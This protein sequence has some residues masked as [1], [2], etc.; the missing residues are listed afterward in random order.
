[1][2]R[3]FGSPASAL[4]AQART[5]TLADCR[6]L[7]YE[8]CLVATGARALVPP[9]PGLAD[10]P[11]MFTFRDQHDG[12]RLT[13]ALGWARSAVVLGGSLVGV[14]LAEVLAGRGLEVTLVDLAPQLLPGAAHP[15]MAEYI[16]GLFEQRGVA[17]RLGHELKAVGERE[18]GP[19]LDFQGRPS[20]E[21]DICCLCIGVRPNLDFLNPTQVPLATGVLVDETQRSRAPGLFAAGD[22]AEGLNAQTG[23]HQWFGLWGKAC[24]QGR[25]AGWNMAGVSRA[26]PGAYAG[27][28]PEF[29][30]PLLGRVFSSLGDPNRQ[31]EGVR[32]ILCRDQQGDP[33][34]VLVL[35]NQVLVGL[36]LLDQVNDLGLLRG[37]LI[38]RLPWPEPRNPQNEVVLDRL[39]AE[40]GGLPASG[41]LKSRQVLRA[42]TPV[43]F[44]I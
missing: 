17:V 28:W 22:A 36:N 32:T 15:L 14:K 42:G 34:A 20:L 5:V 4:D 25:V 41:F 21:A 9:L 37:A 2:T 13:R 16:R 31:G 6:T 38:R 33:K 27:T 10:N 1:V 23:R 18:G 8:Q 19:R 40:L 29:I 35:E 24:Y 7:C 11:R 43:D 26:Y 39:L 44:P 3:H 30:T 12:L